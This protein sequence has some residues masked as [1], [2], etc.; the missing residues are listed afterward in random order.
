[1]LSTCTAF[2]AAVGYF[3]IQHHD[4]A[5]VLV[6]TIAVFLLASGA[7]ALNQIQEAAIDGRMKRTRLRP[8]PSGTLN[9]I[10]A[11]GLSIAL[12]ASG[13]LL[14]AFRGPSTA[15]ALGLFALVWYNV[16]YTNL[17]K[18]TAF[19]SVPGALVG[20]VPPAIGWACAGGELFDVRLLLFCFVL[21]LWQ[22]PHFWVLMF[23]HE[24]EY[25]NAG[26][27]C[28]T[29]VMSRAQA[30]RIIFVWV[31]AAI[32]ASLLLPLSGAIA[33]LF[34]YAALFPAAAWVLWNVRTLLRGPSAPSHSAFRSINAYLFLV[35]ALVSFEQVVLH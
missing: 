11:S 6:P 5:G 8:L 18:R 23:D 9:K 25:A 10:Q 4:N 21:F 1:M 17:K 34:V 12:I 16:I 7:S 22:V 31:S 35:L 19:A 2:S 33:S 29:T 15:V 27:P 32:A 24:D 14:L 28:L 13:L 3:L 30:S 26:I 20:A